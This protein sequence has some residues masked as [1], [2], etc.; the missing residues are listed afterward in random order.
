MTHLF[1]LRLPYVAKLDNT[2]E[3]GQSLV[4]RGQA[5]GDK[6]VL[7]LT[8][9]IP[10]ETSELI[11]HMSCRQKENVYVIN[12]RV[13]GEW[14]KEVRVKGAIDKTSPFTIRIRSHENKFVAYVNG[15]K[16]SEFNY[17]GALAAIT[18]VQV[19][20]DLTL[21][22]VGWEGNYYSVP[23]K[24]S[25]PG[26]FGP[27]RKLFLTFV[28]DDERFDVNFMAGSD[29]AFHFNPRLNKK[30][31]VNNSYFGG[32]WGKEEI[33]SNFPF[34]RKKATDLLF[35]SENEQIG[36]YVDSEPYCTFSQRIDSNKIDGLHIIGS[37]EL[38]VVNFE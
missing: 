7:N 17:R 33:I 1:Y 24:I 18:H 25:I 30:V 12:N 16:I 14:G 35:V 10:S 31:T 5:I 23:Y 4:V 19:L 36:V 37:M 15:K 13:D 34:T 3:P 6:V 2:I 27:Q 11:F 8:N 29:I 28:P 21:N 38:Q 22:A 9:G 32:Q 26:N 20:G